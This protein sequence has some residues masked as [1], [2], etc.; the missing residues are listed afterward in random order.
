MKGEQVK[1]FDSI[2]EHSWYHVKVFLQTDFT[3]IPWGYT[4][5]EDSP[6]HYLLSNEIF[7]PVL[8]KFWNLIPL[9]RFHRQYMSEDDGL[10]L[11]PSENAIHQFKFKFYTTKRI[12]TKM[13][14]IITRDLTILIKDKGLIQRFQI[15]KS[16]DSGERIGSDR[17][18]AWD[19]NIKQTWP[20]FAHGMSVA[21]LI[22]VRKTLDNLLDGGFK[23]KGWLDSCSLEE[24]L[25]MYSNVGREIG[26]L[27]KMNMGHAFLHHL[28]ALFGYKKIM[29]TVQL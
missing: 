12:F 27:W 4:A 21:W 22:L 29:L 14:S 9:W 2:K 1:N 10:R 18:T 13:K 16:S 17:D 11:N 3:N 7:W 19:Y 25:I 15:E 24:K 28:G 26:S 6:I 20:Y 23:D 5:T 8:E